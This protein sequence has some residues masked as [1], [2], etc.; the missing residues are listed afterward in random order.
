MIAANTSGSATGTGNV[1]LNGGI[2]ASGTTG[3]ISGNVLP[4]SAA[5][6][7]A[8]G[9]VGTVGSL[10]IGGLTSTNLTTLNFDLG[11]GTGEITNGDLLTLGTGTV[12]IGS[13]TADDFRRDTGCR[14]RLSPHRRYSSSGAVVD[15][16]PLANFSLPAAPVGTGF[17]LSN[18]VDAGFIDLVVGSSGPGQSDLEQRRRH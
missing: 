1:T 2:L 16:I 8:P 7:I 4:D 17:S 18:T 13:G 10:T 15:A 5:H 12:S 11:T 9:G 14:Q 6:T 3:S